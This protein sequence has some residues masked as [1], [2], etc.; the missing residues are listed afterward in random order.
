MNGA[1]EGIDFYRQ[2]FGGSWMTEGISVAAELGVADLLAQGPLTAKEL[3]AKTGTHGG[4]LY[5]VLRALASVGVFAEDDEGRFSLTPLAELLRSDAAY[6]QRAIAIMMGNEFYATWGELLHSVRT[7]EPGFNERYGMPF[8]KYMEEHPDRH[9][10][11][12]AAMTG[13][14]GGETEPVIDAYDF[15]AFRTVVDVGGGNGLALAS[16]LKR[17][18][19]VRGILFDLPAV[20]DRARPVVSGT[21]VSDRLRIEGGDFFAGVPAEADA[22]VLRHVIHDWENR[23]AIAILRQC[24]KA[25]APDGK[26]LVVEMVVPS[27]NEPG[28]GKWLDLMML[29][30]AGRE[31]TKEEYSKLLSEAGL[32]MTRVI[33]TASDVSIIESMRAL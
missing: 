24:R 28:F 33:P 6:S 13:V 23:D 22:Y 31:R 32:T 11:Y 4:A 19:A 16:I 21:G 14:H 18:P 9:G 1:P 20:A 10:I 2:V 29:L 3:A 5:R 15:S 17:H 7:G 27:G 12:D 30:V 25:M 8:F 26:V